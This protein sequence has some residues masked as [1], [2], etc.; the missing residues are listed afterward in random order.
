MN[1]EPR[2]RSPPPA[3]CMPVTWATV[4]SRLERSGTARK[5][6]SQVRLIAFERLSTSRTRRCGRGWSA[7]FA[8]KD[9]RRVLLLP[10]VDVRGAGRVHERGR[11]AFSPS[12]SAALLER[13]NAKLA[14]GHRER[15]QPTAT[16][17]IKSPR[18]G[19]RHH[20]GRSAGA[21]KTL[22]LENARRPEDHPSGRPGH[23]SS[24]RTPM[25]TASKLESA[26]ITVHPR[27]PK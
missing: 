13:Q 15:R 19:H 8:G 7:P 23:G 17:R 10:E 22:K 25:A 20:D 2:V 26:G 18:N 9:P 3:G 11:A 27:R 16:K 12:F 21:R 14:R 6:A 24:S 5:T 1:R 4:V